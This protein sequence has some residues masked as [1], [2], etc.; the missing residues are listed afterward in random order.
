MKKV[1]KY[2]FLTSAV[3]LC[4]NVGLSPA[5]TVKADEPAKMLESDS[6][7]LSEEQINRLDKYVSLDDLNHFVIDEK[8]SSDLSNFEYDL[9]KTKVAEANTKIDSIKLAQNE[10]TVVSQDSV[11][12]VQEVSELNNS[13]FAFRS[14]FKE[15]KNAVQLYWW[16]A[17]VWLSKSSVNFIGAG[18]TIGGIWVPEPFVSKILATVGV[19]IGLCP[20]GIVFNYTPGVNIWGLEFQ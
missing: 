20:G 5:V 3:S 17:R 19:V 9:L 12:V 10:H 13:S 6:R 15:G 1:F 4:I 2:I 18:I 8:A 7:T 14:T 11:T 16:G